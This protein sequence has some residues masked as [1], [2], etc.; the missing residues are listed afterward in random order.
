MGFMLETL[1]D[2]SYEAIS[3]AYEEVG[4]QKGCHNLF[5]S[6]REASQLIS[7]PNICRSLMHGKATKDLIGVGQ[8]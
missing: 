8:V 7:V 2:V 5:N 3:K 1:P 4:Q 6:K